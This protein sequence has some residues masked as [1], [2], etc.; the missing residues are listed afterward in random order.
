MTSHALIRASIA[1]LTATASLSATTIWAQEANAPS[2]DVARQDL[3][4]I[5]VTGSRTIMDAAH[6]PTPLTTVDISQI[7]VTTPSDTAD[8]LNKLPNIMG[9]RTPRNQGNGSTNNGGNTL[10]L[11]NFGASRT[12]VLLDGHRVAPSNQ[13]GSVNIDVMPQMLVKNVDIV[14]GGASAIY[15]SDAVAGVVNYVLDKEFTGLEV[16]ADYGQSKYSDGDQYQFGAAWGTGLFNDRGHIEMGARFRHQDMIPISARPYGKDGQAWLLTGNG[17][18]EK[19]F[20]NT[21]YARVFNSGPDAGN[22]VCG[23]ACAY[24]D[25]TFDAAGN[26]IPRTHG[27]P[28]NS[29][30]V[31]SGGDGAYTKYGTFR[32]G[33]E[34]K[35]VFARFS[36]DLGESAN[37]YVQGS[38]AEAENESDWIQWVVSPNPG[39]PNSIFSNNPYLT[40]ATQ[41]ALGAGIDCSTAPAGRFC[42]PATP[43]TSP[44]TNSTPPAPPAG[45]ANVP[46]IR[47]PMY[48]D[49]VDG[50]PVNSNP[51][52]M[53]RTLGDQKQWNAE[54]GVTGDI[55]ENWHWDVYYNHANSELTV[56]NPNNTD[57][58]KYL[59][60]LD[61][62][63]DNGTIKCWVSTQPQYASL[64]PGC[65]PINVT[66]PNGISADA[67]NYLRTS[68]SW[69]LTQKLDDIGLSIGGDIGFGLPAGN[70][71]AN[72]SGEARW[73]TY[74]MQ[75]DFL[76]S[77][78]VNCTGLRFCLANG[79]APLRWV[80][81]TNAEVDAKSHVYEYALELNVPL[82]K[83]IPG[84][85]DASVNLAGRRA[86]YSDFDAG[87]SWKIGLNWQIIESVRFRGTLS[88]DFRAPNMNDLYQPAGVSSTGFQDRLTGGSNQG[89]R[90]VTRGNPDL[91][92]ETAKTFTAGVVLTPSFL[93]RFSLAVDYYETK[94]TN[95][96]TGITYQSDAIQ[97]LCLASAPN[98]DSQFCSLAIRPITNPSDPNYTNPAF[99][100]PTEIRSAP[101]NAAVQKTHGIDAQLDYNW[102]MLGG[103][104][105][106]RH[107][108][109]YQPVNETLNTPASTFWTYA[110]QPKLMQTTFL[111]YSNESW[112]V[113]LQNR[114]LS[115]VDLKSSDNDLNGN[116]QNYVDSSLDA[117]DV[118]DLTV[119][120]KFAAW[121]G[122][123]E[124]FINISNLLN[125]RAPL[126]P[127]NSGLPGLF[128]PTLGL[129]D[130]MGRFYTAGFRMKF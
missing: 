54:T 65:V 24:N 46:Y 21:P 96:I 81:N 98:Y 113:A 73:M 118:V 128:Y 32:S 34:M 56:T 27:T 126:F 50:Q 70:I 108:L 36:L 64:Y 25:Y 57:N 1:A 120:K 101:L 53:Y 99:N 125:E 43:A 13:D 22:V 104:F 5:T 83:D 42:L 91:T 77:D 115:S 26:L 106:I 82:L 85:E 109:S 74:N 20:T 78:F 15:G 88:Q 18:P 8:A 86:K 31:E 130:D 116:R 7:A 19:P 38:W 100:M 129:Y 51:D 72:V 60:A 10:S 105:S 123:L 92:P 2:Q 63:D 107:L 61:A 9:G 49:K 12:L 6:S 97:G 121:G 75:S 16:K 76:P 41:A 55:G 44:Q 33:I 119:T 47:V 103:T 122:G 89:E 93:P 127:S 37:W 30:P 52:R 84:F 48:I 112:L 117:Y 90:L 67:Y 62:V 124:G 39:R 102:D 14:T 95:A 94:L 17:T 87:D 3:E 59:A 110:I 69:T 11:R 66:N 35:D 68:T 45:A 114:W 111:S 80:Q 4:T 71:V 79:G 29:P 28:T 23:S 40:P 58:A